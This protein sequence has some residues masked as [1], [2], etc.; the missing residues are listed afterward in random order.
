MLADLRQVTG[1]QKGSDQGV[2]FAPF[3]ASRQALRRRDLFQL[4]KILLLVPVV[5]LALV[6]GAEL[7]PDETMANALVAAGD[8]GPLNGAN[9]AVTIL[10]TRADRWTECTALTM[11]LG[12]DDLAQPVT[13]ALQSRSMLR[14]EQ[15]AVRLQHFADTGDLVA[16]GEYFRYWW[17]DTA[18]LRPSVIAFGI[19]GSR[20]LFQTCLLYTSP[21]PRDQ[22][23]SRMPSSA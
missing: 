14:C 17:A 10:S 19:P 7:I 13:S 22:R 12:D 9:H 11:G 1:P 21:S 23:G 4:V 8:D 20:V 6:I 2:V 16:E 15:A 5:T 3:P 18:L